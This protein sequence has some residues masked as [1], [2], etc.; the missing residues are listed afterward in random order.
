MRKKGRKNFKALVKTKNAYLMNVTGLKFHK[1][2]VFKR[3]FHQKMTAIV[4]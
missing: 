1:H 2:Y 3:S 4:S